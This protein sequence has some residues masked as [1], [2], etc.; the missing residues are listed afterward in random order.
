MNLGS[1]LVLGGFF[2]LVAILFIGVFLTLSTTSS[3]MH[4]LHKNNPRVNSELF[5]NQKG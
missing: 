1:C 4:L 3:G 5:Q 2:A